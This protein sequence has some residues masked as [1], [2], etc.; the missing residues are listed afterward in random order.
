MASLPTNVGY[1]KVVGRFIK[2]V[3]DNLAG[4]NDVDDK[5]DAVPMTGT[6]IFTPAVEWLLNATASPAPVTIVPQ[7][8]ICTLDANGYL[9]DPAGQLGVW[10]VATDDPDNN[11]TGWTYDVSLNFTNVPARNFSIVVPE[12]SVIDLANASPVAG[13]AGSSIVT[14]P[15]GQENIFI[16]EDALDRLMYYGEEGMAFVTGP[17]AD[18]GRQLQALWIEDGA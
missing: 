10:L 4:D 18:G 5:P 15:P 7:Q 8:V 2:A 11:P 3:G 13:S 6:V 17:T 16:G 9:L 14:G 1:G 12:G